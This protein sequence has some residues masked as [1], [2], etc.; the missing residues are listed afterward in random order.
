MKSKSLFIA[1][2]AVVGMATPSFADGGPMG[3]LGSGT[4]FFID[5]PEGIVVDSL[6][7]CPYKATKG[8]AEAFGDE[9]GWKQ[10]I[11]GAVI[12]VPT[13]FAFGIPYGAIAGGRHAFSV[14]WEKP[15]S[16]ESFVVSNEE[17]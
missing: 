8:L 9:N 4:A 17:K 14:G 3:L 15:F 5:V 10:N 13:G 7:K 1:A 12:G 2:L 6:V 16:A 11:V